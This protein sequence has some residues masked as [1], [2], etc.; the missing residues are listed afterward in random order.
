MRLW[1]ISP[2]YLDRQGLLALWRETLLAQKV[3]AKKTTGYKNHPQLTRFKETN[4]P[5]HYI[6][7]YLYSIHQEAN[8][9]DYNFDSKKIGPL[10]NNLKNIT[11]KSGQINY[12]FQH[13]L[14]KLKTRD[15]ERYNRLKDEDNIKLNPLFKVIKGDIESWEKTK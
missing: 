13:L 4:D 2:E 6:A 9:R 15:Q 1:S 11:V 7:R 10:K 14:A 8:N 12:E 5:M 3:L